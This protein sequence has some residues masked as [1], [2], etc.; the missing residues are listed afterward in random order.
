VSRYGAPKKK[1]LGCPRSLIQALRT[2]S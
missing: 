2:V 1:I